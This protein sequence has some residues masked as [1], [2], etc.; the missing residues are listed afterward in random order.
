MLQLGHLDQPLKTFSEFLDLTL[1]HMGIESFQ[2][3]HRGCGIN[4]QAISVTHVLLIVSFKSNLKS[5]LF[6]QAFC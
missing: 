2:L 3:L 5:F 4:Y 6:K 1:L